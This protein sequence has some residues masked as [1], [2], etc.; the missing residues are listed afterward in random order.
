LQKHHNA[1]V[2]FTLIE[3]VF[4]IVILGILA[5]IA[6]PK[7]VATRT[8]AEITSARA[9]IAA[10]RSGIVS[11]RQQRLLQGNTNYIA[12]LGANFTAV[13]AY[14]AKKWTQNSA[15][16]YSVTIAG[17]TCN[18]TYTPADGRFVLATPPGGICD[19]LDF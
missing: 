16:S 17:T 19:N 7:M 8:D 6:V 11:Q 1:K 12:D 18:F 3:L 4:V 15:T 5:A 14:P 10:V 2:A 9:T 13:L